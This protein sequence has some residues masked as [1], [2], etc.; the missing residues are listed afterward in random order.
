MI[1]LLISRVFGLVPI[2]LIVSLLTFG[3]SFMVPGDV[4]DRILGL[5]ATAEQYEELG[6][7]LGLND[8]FLVQYGRW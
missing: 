5:E 6:E 7:R 3:M 1:S 4:R 2:L 8:P